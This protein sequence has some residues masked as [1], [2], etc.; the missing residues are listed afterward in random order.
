MKKILI[1]LLVFICTGCTMVR[2]DTNSTDNIINVVLSKENKLYNQIGRGYKYYI[3]K[4]VNYI[5][6]NDTND[7]LYSNGIYYYLYIDIINYY[8]NKEYEIP[9]N[10]NHYYFKQININNKKGYVDIIEKDGKYLIKFV[11]N[12]AILEASAKKNQINEVILNASYILST[13]KFNDDIVELLMNGDFLKQREEEYDL[14]KSKGDN[15]SFL[16]YTNEE[17]ESD[18]SYSEG[19]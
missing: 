18:T 6:T 11:Y 5:D 14:F 17:I 1:I 16:K 19:E 4:G 10:E 7:K 9:S 12:Y 8:N 15:S 3:P 13:V 2:I